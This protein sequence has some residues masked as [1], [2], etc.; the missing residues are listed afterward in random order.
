MLDQPRKDIIKLIYES[1]EVHIGSALSCVEILLAI[2]QLMQ[3]GDTFILSKAHAQRAA[4][5]INMPGTVEGLVTY[6]NSVGNGIGIGLGICLAKPDKKVFVVVGDGEL[7]EGSN[8]E[9]MRY[10][11]KNKI[12][13]IKIIVDYNGWGAYCTQKSVEYGFPGVEYELECDGHDIERLI[14]HLST[15]ENVTLAKTIKGKGFLEIEDKL[16][17]H[18]HKITKEEM[19]KYCA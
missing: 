5:V 19:E 10:I 9:A 8:W 11:N 15:N 7:D 12:K 3:L 14:A 17:S 1:G 13:N 18:Y 2:K 16:D 4:D 6:C